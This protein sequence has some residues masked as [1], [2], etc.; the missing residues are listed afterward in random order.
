MER[1]AAAGNIEPPIYHLLLEKGYKL[2]LKNHR[3][4]ARKDNLE[5]IANSAV[6]LAG[7]ILLRESKGENWKV[8]DEKIHEYLSFFENLK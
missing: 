4:I 1:I 2:E 3:V 8:S 5:I 7:I 6:E